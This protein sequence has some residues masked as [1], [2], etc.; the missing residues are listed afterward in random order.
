MKI[1]VSEVHLKTNNSN[2]IKIFPPYEII[3]QNIQVNVF[4]YG[5]RRKVIIKR[6]N[7]DEEIIWINSYPNILQKLKGKLKNILPIMAKRDMGFKTMGR[8]IIDGFH[9]KMRIIFE[10]SFIHK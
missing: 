6:E 9:R 1:H 4:S 10:V 8:K 7:V 3:L 2:V 5:I